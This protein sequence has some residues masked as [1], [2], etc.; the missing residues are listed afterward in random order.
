MLTGHEWLLSLCKV[1][2]GAKR[3]IVF[4]RVRGTKRAEFV[5]GKTAVVPR[6]K[7]RFL[8]YPFQRTAISGNSFAYS[9]KFC[10]RHTLVFESQA[11]NRVHVETALIFITPAALC[12]TGERHLK[13]KFMAEENRCCGNCAYHD[14][15]TWAC[16]NPEADDRAD[17]TDDS[18][19]CDCWEDKY[20]KEVSEV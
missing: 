12:A 14:D 8:T 1:V 6:C 10:E 7:V 9:Q 5:D 4:K 18:Y 11:Q 20:V 15:W 19:V 13:E 3:W 16:F 17:F 2:Y